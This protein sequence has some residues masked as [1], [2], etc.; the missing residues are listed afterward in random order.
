M[1]S[2]LLTAVQPDSAPPRSGYRLARLELYNKAAGAET[3]ERSL[4]SYVLGYYKGG[5]Q[6]GTEPSPS[7][8]RLEH[9]DA[10]E[11]AVYRD[12]MADL[13]RPCVR[14]EQERVGFGAV[15]QALRGLRHS[16][17]PGLRE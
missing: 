5:D 2:A 14:L 4:K 11:A 10:E 15:E 1:T 9:L 16:R 17:I 7:A 13:L 12:L 3:R 6:W 8:A